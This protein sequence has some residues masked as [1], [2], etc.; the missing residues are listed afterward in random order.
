MMNKYRPPWYR[1][2]LCFCGWHCTVKYGKHYRR[3][4]YC[5]EDDYSDEWSKIWPWQK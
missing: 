2:I 1:R 3:C 4:F 5:G